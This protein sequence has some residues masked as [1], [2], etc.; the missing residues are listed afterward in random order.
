MWWANG[1]TVSASY[2]VEAGIY[3]GTLSGDPG[4]K[5]ITTGSVA[6]GTASQVQFADIT[7]TVLPPGSY[8][9]FMSC[10]STSATFMR[11][12]VPAGGRWNELVI[13]IQGSVAPGSAPATATPGEPE[14]GDFVPLF[15]FA[16]T[17]SP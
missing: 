3:A 9:M 13:L 11:A 16:T 14:S 17:A 4:I 15:G 7:D 6:Q 10:S 12:A 1:A 5:V 2:N 8:W